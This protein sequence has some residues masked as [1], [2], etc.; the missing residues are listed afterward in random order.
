MAKGYKPIR[1]ER[2]SLVKV[3]TEKE[4]MLRL[5]LNG[6]SIGREQSQLR[7][8][9]SGGDVVPLTL[10]QGSMSTLLW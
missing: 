2:Q 5:M 1:W 6:Q 8:P 7:K 9:I 10:G 4:A 3:A